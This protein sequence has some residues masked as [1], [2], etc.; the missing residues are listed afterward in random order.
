M[1]R[2]RPPRRGLTDLHRPEAP[3][4]G[5]HGT[6][7]RGYGMAGDWI[8]IV[9]GL[10]DEPE[11]VSM[12]Q[13]LSMSEDEV[14]GK[15][16]RIWGWANQH[17]TDGNARGVTF[18]FLD[19]YVGRHL[20]CEAMSSVGWLADSNGTGVIFPGFETY[21]SNSG[22]R[23]FLAARRGKRWRA[24]E[25][26]RNARSVMIALPEK[27]REEKNIES[28]NVLSMP[29]KPRTE[30]QVERDALWDALVAEWKLPMGTLTQ[31]SRI[32]RLV[33]ELKGAGA[34]AADIPIR[35]QRV[36]DAW[37][38]EKATPESVVKHWS[39]F[40]G[41]G[42]VKNRPGRV[43]AAPGKYDG[44]MA[45]ATVIRATQLRGTAD[46]AELAFPAPGE[47]EGNRGG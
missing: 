46:G 37:G 24:N 1:F 10:H 16:C 38:P 6:C 43:E 12:A 36:I 33:T 14:V 34:V 29:K 44:V 4:G 23:R 40:D 3:W 7:L 18:A 30:K 31:R 42:P 20:F 8:P 22:K 47:G 15:L 21:N 2:G 17:T 26:A 27:R 32:G 45:R 25:R 39:L 19:R 41:S 9:I 11:V 5:G 28:T 13:R 35:R